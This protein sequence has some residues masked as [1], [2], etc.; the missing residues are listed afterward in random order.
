ML[1]KDLE[2]RLR[3]KIKDLGGL[4]IKFFCPAFTGLPDRIILMKP[5]R[6]WFVEMKKPGK[7]PTPR[8]RHVHGLL[9]KLG[10]I[11]WVVDSEILLD[12]FLI[13]IQK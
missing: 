7:K 4:A 12:E 2:N 9:Q 5:G 6:I 3:E 10:F 13:E 8:Q 1:E 11:V